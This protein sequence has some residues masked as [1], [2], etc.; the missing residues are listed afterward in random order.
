MAIAAVGEKVPPFEAEATG[1]KTI[2]SEQLRGNP[3]VLYFYPRDNTPGCTIQSKDFRDRHAEFASRGVTVLGVS[4]DTLASHEK[5][6][7]KYEFP[8]DLLS[9]GDETLCGLFDVIRPKNMYGRLVRGIERSTFLF[10]SNGV[11][12]REWRKVRIRGHV[13]EVLDAVKAIEG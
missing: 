2:S 1:G 13:T 11:L 8:F 9:D 6:R 3:F 4:R 10:D 12:L 7:S 5:F